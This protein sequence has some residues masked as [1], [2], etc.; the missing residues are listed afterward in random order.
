MDEQ[1]TDDV[2][3]KVV[4]FLLRKPWYARSKG[5]DSDTESEADSNDERAEAVDNSSWISTSGSQQ[6]EAAFGIPDATLDGDMSGCETPAGASLPEASSSF[7]SPNCDWET[8]AISSSRLP[9]ADREEL[10]KEP[11]NPQQNLNTFIEQ[12]AHIDD[13]DSDKV[14]IILA[15]LS[16]ASE[17]QP[18]SEERWRALLAEAKRKRAERKQASSLQSGRSSGYLDEESMKEDRDSTLTSNLLVEEGEQLRIRRKQATAKHVTE[19]QQPRAE[20]G[21]AEAKHH[22]RRNRWQKLRSISRLLESRP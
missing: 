11:M 7:L 3:P 17:L 4:T 9:Y 12:F 16:A 14:D 2:D 8:N 10:M 5:V 21:R 1:N 20:H 22:S 13:T 15:A 19:I 6:N 18:T